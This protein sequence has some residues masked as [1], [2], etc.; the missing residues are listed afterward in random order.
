MTLI[1]RPYFIFLLSSTTGYNFWP[2]SVPY[3]NSR[4]KKR[5][6]LTAMV[7]IMSI[8]LQLNIANISIVTRVMLLLYNCSMKKMAILSN[9]PFKHSVGSCF[10]YFCSNNE[11]NKAASPS[12]T[13]KYIHVKQTM[14]Q[15]IYWIISLT[16]VT[17]SFLNEPVLQWTIRSYFVVV[18]TFLKNVM[19]ET[20]NVLFL[21]ESL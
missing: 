2:W 16:H 15:S 8:V 17:K 10:V 7:T 20:N 19:T 6:C 5:P 3:K 14:N 11:N 21:G 1:P 13:Q 18:I 4:W 9:L 12:N